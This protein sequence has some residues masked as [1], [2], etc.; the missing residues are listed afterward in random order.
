[1]AAAVEP[2]RPPPTMA[3]SVCRMGRLRIRPPSLQPKGLMKLEG[4]GE[5]SRGLAYLEALKR[6]NAAKGGGTHNLR[7]TMVYRGSSGHD[8]FRN[9]CNHAR[10]GHLTNAHACHHTAANASPDA[11]KQC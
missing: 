9:G 6:V 10:E 11:A 8:L 4:T 2:A 7:S 5:T 3:T 1:M